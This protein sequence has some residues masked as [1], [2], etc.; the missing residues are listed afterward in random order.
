ML[1]DIVIDNVTASHDVSVR[2]INVRSIKQR[3]ISFN[4]IKGNAHEFTIL[5]TSRP[6]LVLSPLEC[7]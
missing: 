1:Q 3:L 2:N 6:P 4:L 5:R 7:I